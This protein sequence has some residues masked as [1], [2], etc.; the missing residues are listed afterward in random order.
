MDGEC[1]AQLQECP[2][3][4]SVVFHKSRRDMP[5]FDMQQRVSLSK[6]LG[7]LKSAGN[8]IKNT[9][10]QAAA[11]ATGV[12]MRRDKDRFEKSLVEEFHRIFTDTSS[13]YYSYTCD[14]TSSLQRLCHLEKHNAS[15]KKA[16]WRTVNDKFFWNK[17]MLRH[18]IETNVS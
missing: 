2:K 5:L 15:K 7:T 9:T 11:M 4:K 17:H 13:F 16:L 10:Q 12:P 3:H 6:T 18:L 14:I 8:A 1:D